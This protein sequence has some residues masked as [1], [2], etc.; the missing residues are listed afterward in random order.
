[1]STRVAWLFA[2]LLLLAPATP[3]SAA[4]RPTREPTLAEAKADFDKADKELNA[5][6]AAAQAKLTPGE[7]ASLREDQRAW[8]QSRDLQAESDP[9][10][11]GAK[12]AEYYTNAAAITRSRTAWLRGLLAGEGTPDSLTGRWSD[13]YGGTL[14]LVEKDGELF[15]TIEVVRGPTAHTGELSG[16]AKWNAPIGWFSDKGRDASKTEETNLSFRWRNRRLEVVGANTMPYHG[17]RAYFDG[18]YVR[19]GSLSASERAELIKSATTPD[20]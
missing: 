17:A 19:I 3:A 12:D 2:I 4:D 7:F 14:Q 15:F 16:V 8:V 10:A 20:P 18:D 9:A 11:A 6:W 13:S 1:M 5:A